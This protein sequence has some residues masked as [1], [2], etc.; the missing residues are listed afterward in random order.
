MCV[1]DRAKQRSGKGPW[2]V[3]VFAF[4]LFFSFS[5]LPFSYLP[6]Y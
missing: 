6:S 3:C 5:F 1:A 2:R 4:S